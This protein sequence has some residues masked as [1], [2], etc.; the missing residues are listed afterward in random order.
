M[1]LQCPY[2]ILI[3][4]GGELMIC[5]YSHIPTVKFHNEKYL[6]SRRATMCAMAWSV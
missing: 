3:G 2:Q 6:T 4:S 5:D 1:C